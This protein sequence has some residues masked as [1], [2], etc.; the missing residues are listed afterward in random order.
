MRKGIDVSVYQRDINWEKTKDYVD[1]VIIRC[2]YGNDLRSQDDPYY[3]KNADECTRLK[4]PFGVYLFSYATNLNMAQSEVEHT[5]R[6][7][8][9]YK[10]EYPI[11]IDIEERN[12]LDLPKD[13]LVEIVEHYCNKI[14]EAGYYVGIYASLSTLN[15]KLSDSKLNKFDKWVAEW[16]KDFTYKGSS[17]MW[18]YTD[19]ARIPGIET[20]VDGDVAFYN[21]PEIIKSN[22]LNHLDDSIEIPDTIELKYKV[23]DELYLNGYLYYSENGNEIIREYCNE[24]AIVIKTNNKKG[25]Q[26]PYELNI[27]GYSKEDALTTTKLNRPCWCSKIA[28]TFKDLRKK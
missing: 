13:K 1:F 3:K 26:A 17:G 20:K 21:Y 8:K 22:G 27:G 5:L 15:N 23:G 4:I 14:E 10:L 19:D 7:I 16:E 12:Q 9:D 28:K 24:P 25:I 2:G 18:Q 11:F 6:L